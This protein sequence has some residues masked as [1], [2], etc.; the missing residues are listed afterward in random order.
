MPLR[1]RHREVHRVWPVSHKRGRDGEEP[2]FQSRRR[3]EQPRK[4]HG[5][6]WEIV[7]KLKQSSSLA[8]AVLARVVAALGGG[9]VQKP[10]LLGG[11]RRE[12]RG[13]LVEVPTGRRRRDVQT[14]EH[15]VARGNRE[16]FLRRIRRRRERVRSRRIRRGDAN[17]RARVD[18]RPPQHEVRADAP[19][20]VYFRVA[21]CV[22]GLAIPGGFARRAA[23]ERERH[24]FEAIADVVRRMR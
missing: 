15:E 12:P 10:F 1:A 11:A 19:R 16:A 24:H 4:R 5:D 9:E 17:E 22:R 23:A 2:R 14:R 20:R 7:Q 13:G 3:L 6:G 8:R 18:P 21:K